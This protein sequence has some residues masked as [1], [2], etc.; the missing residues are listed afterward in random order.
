[1]R[2]AIRTMSSRTKMTIFWLLFGASI[3]LAVAPPLYLAGSGI[4]TPILGIPFSVAYWIVDAL[5]ATGAVWLLWVFENIRGE[6]GE[7][8]EEV[9]A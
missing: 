2:S 6:V 5:L 3:L 7:E 8:P 4:D 9:A 1:M